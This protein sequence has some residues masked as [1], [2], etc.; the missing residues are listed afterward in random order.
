MW[1]DTLLDAFVSGP[2][3]TVDE[4]L[5]AFRDG[6]P[7]RQYISSEPGKYGIKIGLYATL[8]QVMF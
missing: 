5:L 4:Q 2:N 3:I 6:C 8:L 7:S 1:N